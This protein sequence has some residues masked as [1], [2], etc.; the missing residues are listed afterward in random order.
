MDFY[1]IV[2]SVGRDKRVI[3]KPAFIVSKSEDIIIRGRSFYAVWNENLGM[4]STDELDVPRIIDNDLEKTVKS[5]A[6]TGTIAEPYYVRNY[7]SR[8]WT[9][10][11]NYIKTMPDSNIT[12]DNNL[13]FSNTEVNKKDHVSKRLP[14]PLEEG[15]CDAWDELV[16]TLYDPE[17]CEKI[18]WSIGAIVSGDSKR[19]QK[20]L[21]FYGDAG[22]G[23]STILNI[24][25]LLFQGYYTTFE[26]KALT[27]NNNAFSTDAFRSNPLVAIQHDGDLSRIE[28]N[29][30]LNSII[31]HEEMMLNEKYKPSYT[32]RLN[33]FLYMATNRPVKITDSKSGIIRR[34][35][36]VKPSGR[37]LPFK[38]YNYLMHQV[39][40]E[41]GAI[42]WHC[43]Q[44]YKE[45]GIE[46]YDNYRPQLMMYETDPFFNFIEDNYFIF[47]KED[48]ISLKQAWALYKEYRDNASLSY[49]MPMYRFREELKD[50]FREFYPKIRLNGENITSYFKGFIVSKFNIEDSLDNDDTDNSIEEWLHLDKI[51]SIFE[52]ECAECPAQYATSNDIPQKKWDEVTTVLS[53][54]NT[55]GKVHYVKLPENH[56]II[57]FDLKNS[58]GEKSKELNLEEANK[59]PRTYAEY[60]KGGS[61]IHLHY[62]YDGDVNKLSR[63]Y[64][65]SI[66]IKVFTGNSSLRRKLTFCNDLPIAHISSGLPLKE[67][68]S[69]IDF[70]TV[71]NEK[72]I[73]TLIEK[74]LRKEYH[75][76]TAQ[77]VDFI[78]HI[79]EEQYDKG[80]KYDVTDMRPKV[81]A[82]ANNSTNQSTKCLMLVTKMKFRSKDDTWEDNNASSELNDDELIF[83]DVEVFPNLFLVNYKVSGE[84]KNVVRMINPTPKDIEPLFNKK[85]VGFN[86]RR[87]DNHILYAR[88]LGYNNEE[89]FEL[90]KKIISSDKHDESQRNCFFR[91]AYNLSYTDVYDF[92]SKK[93]SLKKWEIELGIHH[94]ELGL[95]WDQP[96]PEDQWIKVAEYCDNDVIATE[97]VFNHLRGDW[98]ARQILA[99]LAGMNVNSTTNQLTTKIIF[100]NDKNPKLV[101]TD[102]ATGKQW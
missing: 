35:I 10:Y 54:L 101:Y 22:S 68:S 89:L 53:D 85:L 1:R 39:E 92:A 98:T 40:F 84:G 49:G 36:D 87:Y 37:K 76:S 69:V 12:L 18:E 67:V 74:N 94:Q 28:D 6:E 30:K 21:V 63:I 44:V 48:G 43:L 24:I 19:I 86:C 81:M 97:A 38:R 50:Y 83:Y 62:I 57:D 82:F 75:S 72:A 58:N 9:E 45:L 31:S 33:C 60:S 78:Y 3:A 4:W 79:L 80:A 59:W 73:R 34:L 11:N 41:L 95:P 13:T 17:E 29:S 91:E 23:K 61:G 51:D 66:E 71:L 64:S 55:S 70:D 2:T 90:S 14:Y 99:N 32:A 77:S 7:N 15:S 42:A 26:A 5:L 56:I 93:Q 52:K 47:K 102:L 16:G 27:S 65:E 88:Y 25:Q 100:G 20:F 8:S 96:V 46:Y